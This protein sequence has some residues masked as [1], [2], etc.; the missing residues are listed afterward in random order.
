M[1]SLE[2]IEIIDLISVWM[3]EPQL[4]EFLLELMK[5]GY[6]VARIIPKGLGGYDL[7]FIEPNV[8]AIKGSTRLLYNPGRRTITLKSP[9]VDELLSIFNDVEDTL[10]NVGSDPEKGVLF[11]EINV[12]AKAI[13]DKLVLRSPIK[14]N[15][16]LGSDLSVIPTNFVCE[17]GDPNSRKWFHLSIKPI[18]T[19]WPENRVRYEVVLIYRNSRETLISLLRELDNALKG[20]IERIN[21]TLEGNE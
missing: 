3:L 12:K 18:W 2:N 4:P 1:I 19:S 17:G 14:T 11:Y 13:G 15:D 8:I 5:K 7:T 6:A 10:K 21:V 20:I 16:L 9:K